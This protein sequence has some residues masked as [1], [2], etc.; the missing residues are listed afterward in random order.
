MGG[1]TL[2]T[3]PPRNQSIGLPRFNFLAV[4]EKAADFK[5]LLQP[6]PNSHTHDTATSSLPGFAACLLCRAQLRLAGFLT[7]ACG[8]GFPAPYHQG[9]RSLMGA[10]RKTREIQRAM[11][12]YGR[13]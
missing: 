4:V 9:P 7:V 12:G 2:Q 10:H 11:A 8:S 5:A 6:S 13:V 1:A 3:L